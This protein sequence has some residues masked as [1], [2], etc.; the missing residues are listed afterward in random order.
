MKKYL[1]QIIPGLLIVL[2]GYFGTVGV[3]ETYTR[4]TMAPQAVSVVE[5]STDAGWQLKEPAES[6]E[7]IAG[8]LAASVGELCV[9][10]LNDPGTKADWIIVRQSASDPPVTCYIDSS[11]SSLAF[12]SNIPAQYTII[13]A[14]VEDGEPKILTH[15]CEYGLSPE[16]SP[17]PTPT[18]PPPQPVNLGEWVKQ[19]IPD[20]G[21]GQ[22]AALASCYESAAD[23]IDKGSIRTTE[24]AYSTLRTAT[25]TKIKPE[26]WGPFLD[27]LAIKVTE[28]MAGSN[29]TRKL[30]TIFSEIA[31]GLRLQASDDRLQEEVFQIP[32]WESLPEARS[33]KSDA[34]STPPAANCDSPSG[35]CPNP[36]VKPTPII[37]RS[38]R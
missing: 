32:D 27:Q 7:F 37:N 14:I 12:A 30:G 29:D 20:A 24:A 19:N 18:P 31:N 21:R 28:N 9:F 36:V 4:M 33:L 10:R 5:K 25:Q 15:I 38:R 16:P 26:I 22:C 3:K 11:G 17:S 6:A 2:V 13:A 8:P 35:V 34:F 23:G 1:Q